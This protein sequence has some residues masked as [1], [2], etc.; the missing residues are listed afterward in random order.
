M[1][2]EQPNKF[3]Q[4]GEYSQKY[5]WGYFA[6]IIAFVIPV[7][8]IFADVLFKSNPLVLS[9]QNGDLAREFLNWR[10][11]GFKELAHGNLALWNPHVFSGIPFFGGFQS[12]LL[13]P[14][15][16]LF[17][18]LPLNL[19]FN[20]SIVL[21]IL[22]AGLFMFLWAWHRG[23]KPQAC[24]LT[25]ILIMFCGPYFMHIYAGHVSNLCAMSWV[26]L[27]FLCIDCIF[28]KRT[29][30]W[31][32]V[33]VAA[34]SMFI[35]AGH[36]QYVFY[37]AIAS[38]IYS[39]LL[40]KNCSDRP[41]VL[42]LLSIMVVWAGLL[43][44]VQLLTGLQE[45]A[46]AIRGDEGRGIGFAAFFSFPPENIITLF[47][48]GFFG[49]IPDSYW[50]R[51]YLWEMSAFFS[52]TGLVLAVYG[53]IYGSSQQRRFCLTLIII[54]F[55]LA[56]GGH[57]PLFKIL[58]NIIPGF[59]KFRG[60]SKFIFPMIVFASML[61]GI[62]LNQLITIKTKPSWKWIISLTLV[63][64]ALIVISISIAGSISQNSSTNCWH[65]FMKFVQSQGIKF[66]E[67]Y[68]Q[69]DLY[70]NPKF[71]SFAAFRSAKALMV[72]GGLLLFLAGLFAL[73]RK[74]KFSSYLIILLALAELVNF[75]L[76]IRVTF[77]PSAK[78]LPQQFI[79]TISNTPGDIRTFNRFN[80]NSAMTDGLFDV[81]GDQPDILRRYAYFMA[82]TESS[83]ANSQF[84]HPFF[85]LLRLKF[86]IDPNG[87]NPQIVKLNNSTLPHLLLVNDFKVLEDREAILNLLTSPDFKSNKTVVL[88]SQPEPLPQVSDNNS[89]VKIIDESTDYLDIEAHI[90]SPAILL[91]TD[92]Y[93]PNWKVSALQGSCQSKYELMPADYVLRAVPLSKGFHKFRMEYRAAAFVAGLWISIISVFSYITLCLCRIF[94]FFKKK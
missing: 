10:Y 13:Y 78:K 70:D 68:L 56:L 41:R 14:P 1:T 53:Q 47:A 60:S 30:N 22:L 18:I 36:P 88:E 8:I 2:S 12:A 16:F 63:S 67:S 87:G 23:L 74:L 39:L 19:A 45:S 29:L 55:I 83:D 20:I 92:V 32:L 9:N 84:S 77:D 59:D 65:D 71:V 11:F 75:A 51:C 3:K 17:M 38:A 50:G 5:I 49:S 34:V 61:A 24:F 73:K 90:N 40:L 33:G 58:Y 44:S 27:V 54:L 35:L 26:P 46:Y 82:Y 76:P 57:T 85:S 31:A 37:T 42:M 28:E 69:A 52:V 80:R 89:T 4:P 48:P 72:A 15:N 66:K 94:S 91:V 81:W 93:H 6:A 7:I 21:H 25:S 43:V 79:N 62:G 64:I 86:I